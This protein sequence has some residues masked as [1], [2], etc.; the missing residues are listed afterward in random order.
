MGPVTGL[1]V[2]VWNQRAPDMRGVMATI[3]PSPCGPEHGWKPLLEGAM[4]SH[5]H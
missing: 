1:I 5:S 3:P 4:H 2:A